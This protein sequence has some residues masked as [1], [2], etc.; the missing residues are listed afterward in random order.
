MGAAC[1]TCS[2][3][4][5]LGAHLWFPDQ[6]RLLFYYYRLTEPNFFVFHL[7]EPT[8]YYTIRIP[9]VPYLHHDRFPVL[10]PEGRKLVFTRVRMDGF[11][12][13]MGD[14][15]FRGDH[16]ALR[17]LRW[18]YPPP[19]SDPGNPEQLW[20]SKAWYE[21]KSFTDGG[22]TLVF[23][24]TMG[25]GG[26]VDLFTLSLTSGT[27]QRITSH[28]EWDETV[29][30]SPDG[31]W[32]A[33]ESTRAHWIL[34]YFSRIPIPP[35][36]D[37]VMVFPLVTFTLAG[38]FFAPHEP[39]L[40]AREGDLPTSIG[41]R[42]S[43]E[44]DEGWGV[45]EGVHWSPEGT[46]LVYGSLLGSPLRDTRIG[47]VYLRDRSPAFAPPP[48]AT[49][50]PPWAVP[51]ESVPLHPFSIHRRFPGPLGGTVEV[52][53]EGGLFAG[54]FSMRLEDY[55][56]RSGEQVSGEVALDLPFLGAAFFRSALRL[57]GCREGESYHDLAI[58]NGRGSGRLGFRIGSLKR[59]ILFP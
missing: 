58:V 43:A 31:R 59:E 44:G 36:L 18:L 45:R 46:R 28:P 52:S 41:Y 37:W 2:L 53:L 10:S 8:T 25:E 39:I 50:D 20:L 9:E 57:K 7:S 4:I 40:L 3:P 23:A 24:S 47:V 56:F 14:L 22:T 1:L 34:G 54:A 33:F 21:A 6:K 42:L 48:S 51:G 15:E 16:Y 29:E 55:A 5:S 19:L 17:N 32:L 27:V 35:F 49:P 30:F 12:L 11:S 13:W 26:N 38:N